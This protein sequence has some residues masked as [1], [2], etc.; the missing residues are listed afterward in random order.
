MERFQNVI[1]FAAVGHTHKETYQIAN[2][3]TNP[4][5]PVVVATVGGSVTTYD[6]NNP[7]FMVLDLDLATML[8]TNMHSYYIDVE[9]ANKAG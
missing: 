1:R 9:V 2:S 6:Y 3:M 8:P 4:E 7:S 5:K